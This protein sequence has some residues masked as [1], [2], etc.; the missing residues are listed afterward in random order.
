MLQRGVL[1]NRIRGESGSGA[2]LG[3]QISEVQ[4][5]GGK[6]DISNSNDLISGDK[7]EMGGKKNNYNNRK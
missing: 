1:R 3:T 6:L 4:V 2:N 5:G 7:G